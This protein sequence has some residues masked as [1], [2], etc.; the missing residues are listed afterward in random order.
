MQC[1]VHKSSPV[2]NCLE[3]SGLTRPKILAPG[4]KV[5]LAAL[6]AQRTEHAEQAAL[7]AW[8][9]SMTN[10]HPELA[11]LF[12]VPNFLG[13]VGKKTARLNAGKRAKAEGRKAGVEDVLLLVARGG[14]H[15][16]CIEMKREQGVPSDVDPLQKEWHVKHTMRGYCVRV[17]FGADQAK[18][19]LLWYLS[20]PKTKVA[21]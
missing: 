19:V 7:F 9:A 17:C 3:C 21:A 2:L 14:Y 8:A 10:A 5:L 6:N 15:G 1:R 12:A 11:E 16:L 13:H 20:Q 18:A 4:N